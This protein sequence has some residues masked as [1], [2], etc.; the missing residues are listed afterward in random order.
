MHASI[1][2]QLQGPVEKVST[3]AFVTKLST[4]YFSCKL[5]VQERP[6][7]LRYVLTYLCAVSSALSIPFHASEPNWRMLFVDSQ[8]Q[9]TS[10]AQRLPKNPKLKQ[11]HEIWSVSKFFGF[12]AAQ[13]PL[14]L[15]AMTAGA[16]VTPEME[17]LTL[18]AM[19]ADLK[20]TC[21]ANVT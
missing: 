18:A 2:R 6:S 12:P 21:F 13:K 4:H 9:L 19:I 8:A 15:Q 3:K 17:S 5:A 14:K 7:S 10:W 11:T 20:P 1:T 16:Y